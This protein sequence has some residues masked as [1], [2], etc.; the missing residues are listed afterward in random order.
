MAKL[1]T[2]SEQIKTWS[3]TSRKIRTVMAKCDESNFVDANRLQHCLDQL[4]MAI[5]SSMSLPAMV[6]RLKSHAKQAGMK[7]H[8][9]HSLKEIFISSDVFYVEI[10]LENS[11][12][13]EDVKIFRQDEAVSCPEMCDCLRQSN[14]KGFLDHLKGLNSF[15]QLPCEISMKRDA[16]KCLQTLEDDVKTL[17]EMSCLNTTNVLILILSG[18]AGF[19]TPRIG[20]YPMR[21]TFFVSP[22]DLLNV[23]K[24]TSTILN[25]SDPLPENI[26]LSLSVLLEGSHIRKL[27]SSGTLYSNVHTDSKKGPL[28]NFVPLNNS[29][30]MN[31][32]AC[33][34]LK[35]NKPMP[36]STIQIKRLAISQIQGIGLS[37]AAPLNSLICRHAQD[38]KLPADSR[39][40]AQNKFYVNL[41]GEQHCY[42]ISECNKDMKGVM[43]STIPLT[44]TSQAI[45]IVTALRQQAVYNTLL[46]SCVRSDTCKD[47]SDVLLFE[48]STVS[49]Y[50]LTITF[51][52]PAKIGMVCVELDMSEVVNVKC[53]I[54]MPVGEEPLCTNEYATKVLQKCMSIPVTM[55]AI[56]KVANSNIEKYRQPLSSSAV[57]AKFSPGSENSQPQNPGKGS[58]GGVSPK[59]GSTTMNY[60]ASGRIGVGTSR[61]SMSNSIL[62]DLSNSVATFF[63]PKNVSP[64]VQERSK[65]SEE[66]KKSQNP[67]LAELLTSCTV[68]GNSSNNSNANPLPVTSDRGHQALRQDRTT[69]GGL[70]ILK[71]KN[72]SMSDSKSPRQLS[73]SDD[74]VFLPQNT[75]K[76]Q[77]STLTPEISPR[78]SSVSDISMPP[79]TNADLNQLLSAHD[80]SVLMTSP[81]LSTFT[82]STKRQKL[83]GSSDVQC[84]SHWTVPSIQTSWKEQ[85]YKSGSKNS[86]SKSKDTLSIGE[87]IQI[88]LPERSKNIVDVQDLPENVFSSDNFLSVGDANNEDFPDLD[89]D[90]VN[91]LD[92][93]AVFGKC[94]INKDSASFLH[95][96]PLSASYPLL[97]S[98]KPP[99][100]NR[101]QS[102]DDQVVIKAEMIEQILPSVLE[103]TPVKQPHIKSKGK[104]K[105][106]K[107]DIEESSLSSDT[108]PSPPKKIKRKAKKKESSSNVISLDH[109][110]KGKK[111]RRLETE[112]PQTKG[113]FT[114]TASSDP[115]KIKFSRT[116]SEPKKQTQVAE[117]KKVNQMPANVKPTKIT[118]RLPPATGETSSLRA[119]DQQ[120]KKDPER[121]GATDKRGNVFEVFGSKSSDKSLNVEKR[122]VVLSEE[123]SKSIGFRHEGKQSTIFNKK[124]VPQKGLSR[125]VSQ[126]ITMH[127]NDKMQ[128]VL[129]KVNVLKKSTSSPAT[130]AILAKKLVTQKARFGSSKTSSKTIIQGQYTLQSTSEIMNKCTSSGVSSLKTP[131]TVNVSKQ[132]SGTKVSLS[133]PPPLTLSPS[134]SSS[135]T[136][137]QRPVSTPLSPSSAGGPKKNKSPFR[138]RTLTSIVQVL[139]MKA[140]TQNPEDELN[141]AV[142]LKKASEPPR[143]RSSSLECDNKTNLLTKLPSVVKIQKQKVVST[144][145]SKSPTFSNTSKTGTTRLFSK[146]VGHSTKLSL[147]TCGPSS[148]SSPK[149]N[150]MSQHLSRAL[151]TSSPSNKVQSPTSHK[152]Q[153]KNSPCKSLQKSPSSPMKSFVKT[154]GIQS[155]V[156]RKPNILS[157]APKSTSSPKTQNLSVPGKGSFPQPVISRPNIT[158]ESSKKQTMTV[159]TSTNN[160]ITSIKSTSSNLN[161]SCK[162]SSASG[163]GSF[164][165]GDSTG[166][167]AI[168]AISS[169]VCKLENQMTKETCSDDPSSKMIH[170]S[171]NIAKNKEETQNHKVSIRKVPEENSEPTLDSFDQSKSNDGDASKSTVTHFRVPTPSIVSNP[172]PLHVGSKLMA[173]HSVTGKT[174]VNYSLTLAAETSGNTVQPSTRSQPTTDVPQV[175]E[176]IV[177]RILK[178]R[179]TGK[180]LSP[181]PSDAYGHS[182]RKPLVIDDHQDSVNSRSP[183]IRQQK[184]EAGQPENPSSDTQTE[185]GSTSPRSMIV[186]SPL[187][188]VASSPLG[189]VTSPLVLPVKS[190]AALS[191]TSNQASPCPIDDDLMD[192]ALVS[193]I[194]KEDN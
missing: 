139:Q 178:K 48:V 79:T 107:P 103:V 71:R 85:D 60:I 158:I 111:K 86:Q 51:E 124:T 83:S 67:M 189:H 183:E 179:N 21:L 38:P 156:P 137:S 43:V 132:F 153:Q 13:V 56:M 97:S 174:T 143:P 161:S 120:P 125:D 164:S 22:Y 145:P 87:P 59:P 126:T 163:S 75:N 192:E 80:T 150:K 62:F 23:E 114:M 7:F 155:P 72:R 69:S 34:V 177:S 171:N 182:E 14:F 98:G 151:P 42:F 194:S 66:S 82:D 12:L 181:M 186:Q 127:N 96:N 47:E 46:A 123:F 55:R 77:I 20:G 135:S 166:K 32:P 149:V 109:P 191:G 91:L 102:A 78:G 27:Q 136:A 3:D 94:D 8:T 45:A 173:P 70:P 128:S 122:K 40:L 118:L 188:I 68:A 170:D 58:S 30:S 175:E 193:V 6:E 53:I 160:N 117:P 61:K 81:G 90:D 64:Q 37:S 89:P 165:G 106:F 26:G 134:I 168:S 148:T 162:T 190:P 146:T 33:F 36:L 54:H 73:E 18:L 44:C 138:A 112:E 15:Y 88:D 157:K 154:A 17:F 29:N 184:R 2:T 31:L 9:G 84:P 110:R 65:S 180:S 1:K 108:S 141:E 129:K 113:S 185:P 115:L 10:I 133:K 93:A 172:K 4:K 92:E 16:F 25:M 35:L 50:K 116:G 95:S 159:K 101:C 187:C 11:G 5:K 19:V 28:Y 105:N 76:Q 147:V 100:N 131:Q 52:H 121:K 119:S 24:K 63:A 167:T 169:D 142:E 140:Q 104:P 57:P 99:L 144:V 130:K 49:Q 74:T 41:P 39:P 152:I 176:D